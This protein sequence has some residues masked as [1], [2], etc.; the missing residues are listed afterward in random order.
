MMRGSGLR[1]RMGGWAIGMDFA[2]TVVGGVVLGLSLDWAFNTS[3]IFLLIFMI[4]GLVGGFAVFLRAGLKASRNTTYRPPA[5]EASPEPDELEDPW[6]A[7]DLH[8]PRDEQ[9]P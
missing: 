5:D 6:D 4:T 9:A 2:W 8:D 7:E 3:P 1:N